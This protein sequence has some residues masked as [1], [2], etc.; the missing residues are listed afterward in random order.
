MF[1]VVFTFP[2]KCP[3]E[4][5]RER[6]SKAV[7]IIFEIGRQFLLK[8]LFLIKT[9]TEVQETMRQIDW[10]DQMKKHVEDC[11]CGSRGNISPDDIDLSMAYV[12]F[13]DGE[14]IE[15][16]QL[17]TKGWGQAK[18][19]ARH[20]RLGDEIERMRILRNKLCHSPFA[21]MTEDEFNAIVAEA[22]D[23]IHRQYREPDVLKIM[24]I[25]SDVNRVVESNLAFWEVNNIIERFIREVKRATVPGKR[26]RD[27]D[28]T[29]AVMVSMLFP[30]QTMGTTI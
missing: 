9:K 23:I 19:N 14:I 12:I 11:L 27:L 20:L 7:H 28:G 18:V 22:K 21:A 15:R 2:V 3:D 13:R 30:L 26:T 4:K 29:M 17:P 6:F 24:D 8:I 25:L 1:F 10:N 5:S 16:K